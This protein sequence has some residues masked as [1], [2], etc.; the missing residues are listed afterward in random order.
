MVTETNT[1]LDMTWHA[2]KTKNEEHRLWQ[3]MARKHR[4][5]RK[6]GQ[7]QTHQDKETHRT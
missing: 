5:G 6:A 2:D 3:G 1:N 4:P 7:K